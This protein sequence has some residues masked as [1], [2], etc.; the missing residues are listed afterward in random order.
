MDIVP[1][2]NLLRSPRGE[3]IDYGLLIGEGTDNAFDAGATMLEITLAPD[4]LT[5]QDNGVGITRDRTGLFHV[6]AR[7]LNAVQGTPQRAA[8]A[9]S[10]KGNARSVGLGPENR[11]APGADSENGR[12]GQKFGR[13]ARLG[14]GGRED[15]AT[16]PLGAGWPNLAS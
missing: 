13:T 14:L 8:A 10:L 9:A 7:R 1:S 5:F 15:S 2:A 11:P 3:R 16:G 12:Q 6:I 4:A